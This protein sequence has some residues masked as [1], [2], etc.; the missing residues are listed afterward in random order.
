MAEA[1]ECWRDGWKLRWL[2][3][4]TVTRLAISG[5]CSAARNHQLRRRRRQKVRDPGGRSRCPSIPKEEWVQR[6]SAG[7]TERACCSWGCC[8]RRSA[9][10]SPVGCRSRLLW[11]V[12]PTSTGGAYIVCRVDPTTAVCSS[13][14]WCVTVVLCGAAA[15]VGLVWF[16]S[17]SICGSEDLS[18][19][20]RHADPRS[21]FG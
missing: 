2:T 5:L 18:K 16:Q 1:A 10:L 8:C 3:R 21:F 12:S 20:G 14:F 13:M 7:R 11:H 9:S 19:S 4:G 6:T 15:L 17:A